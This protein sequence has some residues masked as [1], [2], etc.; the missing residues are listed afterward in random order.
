[1]LASTP[2]FRRRLK[3]AT[4][5]TL[6]ELVV[7]ICIIALVAL[8]TFPLVGYFKRR[9]YDARCM[10]NLRT[11][12]GALSAYMSEH[13]QV[14]P[15]DPHQGN[16]PDGSPQAKWWY[17]TLKPFGASRITWICPEHTVDPTTT[18]DEENY[19]FS[20]IPTPFDDE[21]QVAYKWMQPWV[22]EFG[23]VHDGNMANQVMPDG[24]LRKQENPT[25]IKKK[26]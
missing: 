22:I 23:G 25:P 19:D 6:V 24:S 18:S 10:G 11:L 14:W 5:L 7:V 20:Y 12:H 1:M 13:G 9:A 21:P 16:D 2:H 8:F 3:R 15:Q 4:G 17:D 26:K